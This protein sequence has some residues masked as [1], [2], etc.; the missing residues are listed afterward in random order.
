LIGVLTPT[1]ESELNVAASMDKAV[2]L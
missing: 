1:D 2:I